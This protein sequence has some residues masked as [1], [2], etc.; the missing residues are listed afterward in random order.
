MHTFF[1][2]RKFTLYLSKYFPERYNNIE[3]DNSQNPKNKLEK[4]RTAKKL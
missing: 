2:L 3:L 4:S 1:L